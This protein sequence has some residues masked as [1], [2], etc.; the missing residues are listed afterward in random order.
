MIRQGRL[1]AHNP[2]AFA[3]DRAALLTL[4]TG[5]GALMKTESAEEVETR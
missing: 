1:A 2:A 5:R 4:R 3:I